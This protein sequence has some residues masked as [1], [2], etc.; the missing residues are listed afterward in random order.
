MNDLHVLIFADKMKIF[1][2]KHKSRWYNIAVEQS[3]ATSCIEN[4]GC[5]AAETDFT[6]P[7]Y[8]IRIIPA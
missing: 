5:L 7:S 1:L 4:Q 8:L 2:D 6:E 3:S